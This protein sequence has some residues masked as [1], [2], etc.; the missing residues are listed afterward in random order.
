V[1]GW[2]PGDVDR[3]AARRL[4]PGRR[5]GIRRT[6][7]LVD[8]P[9]AAGVAWLSHQYLARRES[10]EGRV[11]VFDMGGGTLDIAVLKVKGGAKPD[12]S[13]LA[14]IGLPE[15]G[16]DLDRAMLRDFTD[17]LRARG[18]ELHGHPR[19]PELRGELLRA[20]RDAKIFLSVNPSRAIALT[21]ERFGGVD[22]FTYTRDSWRR[23]SR[24]S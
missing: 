17:A 6:R 22:G 13:V 8:E 12:V 16:D 5:P 9:V 14:A 10:P 2:L 15:A 4:A 18:F 20:A 24:P 21:A 23:R 7:H 1:V 3:P 11:L 19:E